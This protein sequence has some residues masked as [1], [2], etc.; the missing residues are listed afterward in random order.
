MLKVSVSGVRGIWGK[1]LN[2]NIIID[3][4]KAYIAYIKPKKVSIAT[5]TRISGNVIKLLVKSVLNSYGIKILDLGV[6]PT[7]LLLYAVN[8]L[9]LDGGIIITSSHNPVEWNGLKFVKSGGVFLDNNDIK[10]LQENFINKNFKE[11]SI[12]TLKEDEES[13]NIIEDYLEE[14]SKYIDFNLIKKQKFK[15]AIDAGNGAI[16]AV[17]DKIL[18]KLNIEYTII[19]KKPGLFE[20]NPEPVPDA[21]NKLVEKVKE[22]K[23][24]IGFAYDPDADRLAL[25]TEN[26]PVGEDYT[27]AIA[28][29]NM[30]DKGIKTDIVINFSTSSI[31]D[32]IAKM[33]NQ[34]VYRSKVGEI[35]VTEEIKKRDTLI[36]GEGNG[37]VILYNFNKCR[38]SIVAT[39]ILLEYL[40][41]KKQSLIEVIESLPKFYIIKDKIETDWNNK[42]I[43]IV[44]DTISKNKVTIVSESI[45]DGLWFKLEKGFLHIRGSNTEPIVRI[46]GESNKKEFISNIIGEIKDGIRKGCCC[47]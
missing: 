41:R 12:Y 4:I 25:V 2:H 23:S 18:S 1:D 46:I 27:L 6:L 28:Y 35:N 37:G 32:E 15:I 31:I 16:L 33:F 24:E 40:A 30:L 36:G 14:L 19:H 47:N 22:T 38:D 7:P 5:D 11:F 21:L 29:L 43:E 26:G 9:K 13:Y 44:K 17:I 10:V 8:K 45:E 39:L 3:Y 34:N 20:R 42:I